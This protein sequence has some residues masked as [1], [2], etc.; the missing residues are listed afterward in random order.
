MQYNCRHNRHIDD[1]LQGIICPSWRRDP[2]E[3][4][5]QYFVA[6]QVC[7]QIRQ[8]AQLTLTPQRFPA[9]AQ[10]VPSATS[11]RW[12]CADEGTTG[13]SRSTA[14]R[15]VTGPPIRWKL[16]G[17]SQSISCKCRANSLIY[18]GNL[19]WAGRLV[20]DFC[21][22][23]HIFKWKGACVYGVVFG[24]D[25]ILRPR[26]PGIGLDTT[27]QAASCTFTQAQPYH[28]DP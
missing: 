20:I 18:H 25:T 27:F 8:L 17:K 14:D 23:S 4:D 7:R 16:F 5:A 12:C 28:L 9:L 6:R 2:A 24:T 11:F 19:R 22:G 3:S 13:W 26:G 21:T 1:R 15:L 10:P